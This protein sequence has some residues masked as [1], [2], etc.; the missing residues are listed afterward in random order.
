VKNSNENVHMLR[1]EEVMESATG[2]NDGEKAIIR[3]IAT[4]TATDLV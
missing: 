4:T 1:L 3:R 2:L